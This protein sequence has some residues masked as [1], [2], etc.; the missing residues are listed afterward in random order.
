[1]QSP[2][3][4]EVYTIKSH[5]SVSWQH[6]ARKMN[7]IRPIP[8]LTFGIF[9]SCV[10]LSHSRPIKLGRVPDSTL[11]DEARGKVIRVFITRVG[12]SGRSCEHP[13]GPIVVFIPNMPYFIHLHPILLLYWM[14][15][16]NNKQSSTTPHVLLCIVHSVR[17]TNL[18]S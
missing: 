15:E 6:H 3:S 13:I 11:H 8:T 18:A 10:P 12:R 17:T 9:P 5:H 16:I 4:D 1:M 7:D 14:I 2:S